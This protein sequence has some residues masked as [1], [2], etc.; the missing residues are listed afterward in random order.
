MKDFL[1]SVKFKIIV[2]ILSVLVGMMIYGATQPG[3]STGVSN[4]FMDIFR[5]VQEFSSKI[6]NKVQSSLDMLLN[7]D[8][9]YNDNEKLKKQLDELYVNIIDYEK[10][11]EENENLHDV[12]EIKEKN[13][14]FEFSPPCNIIA[15]NTNDPYN[16]FTIDKGSADGISLYD[17]VITGSG[18]VGKV[19]SISKNTAKI[20]TIFSPDVPVGVFCITS[21][22]TGLLEGT[23]EFAKD[24]YVKM[25]Y[26]DKQSTLAV[27][28][29]I[30]TAGN[31]GLFP[32]NQ[33]VGT[34]VEMGTEDNGLSL[35]AKIE[36]SVK[37]KDITTVFVITSFDGQGEGY[38][39]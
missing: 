24:G 38:G 6:S 11:K 26:I 9:Y 14:D 30:C 10:I 32:K 19:V 20:K 8:K 31:S 25:K 1:S 12:L 13:Q 34:I 33:L 37:I 2:G 15:K 4:F 35:Y 22:E 27:G 16:T 36:P 29:I 5:P 23:Y 7:A 21:K 28:D 3:F 17:P 18:L 39:D